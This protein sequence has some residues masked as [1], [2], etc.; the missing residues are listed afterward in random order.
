MARQGVGLRAAGLCDFGGV[1]R[2]CRLYRRWCWRRAAGPIERGCG[3]VDGVVAAGGPCRSNGGLEQSGRRSL[4]PPQGE[5][6]TGCLF[7][8]CHA[9]RSLHIGGLGAQVSHTARHML[10]IW[11]PSERCAGVMHATASARRCFATCR[12]LSWVWGSRGSGGC[13]S[14]GEIRFRMWSNP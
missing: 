3:M 5:E 2:R 13:T 9:V 11:G 8:G 10:C 6:G 12:A 1:G 14:F 7:D 4:P